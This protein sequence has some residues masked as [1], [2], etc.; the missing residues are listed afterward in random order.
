MVAAIYNM[1]SLGLISTDGYPQ[2]LHC[3]C[4]DPEASGGANSGYPCCFG[5]I[6][7]HLCVYI[8]DIE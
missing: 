2:V 4:Q 3:G 1:R 6:L 8:K 5:D 7:V